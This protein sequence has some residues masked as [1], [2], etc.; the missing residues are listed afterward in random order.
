M[1]KVRIKNRFWFWA[2]VVLFDA[3]NYYLFNFVRKG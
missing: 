2:G 3:V 1:I